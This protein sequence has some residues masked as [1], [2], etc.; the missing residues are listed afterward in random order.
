MAC[1][2]SCRQSCIQSSICPTSEL[3][4]TPMD[5]FS[6]SVTTS[7]SCQSSVI[8]PPSQC[9]FLCQRACLQTPSSIMS[10]LPT[11]YLTAGNLAVAPTFAI[12]HT[13]PNPSSQLQSIVTPC[14]CATDEAFCPCVQSSTPCLQSCLNDCKLTCGSTSQGSYPE[15]RQ[16]C[17][18]FCRK[19]CQRSCNN[20]SFDGN[21]SQ[22][23]GN[24][25]E[26]LD[27]NLANILDTLQKLPNIDNLPHSV[28][29]EMLPGDEVG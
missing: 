1:Q 12:Q 29:Q 9:H 14:E 6:D 17:D 27:N 26:Q 10:P 19:N 13:N 21:R 25:K 18:L 16:Q 8:S 4:E 20:K 23:Y 15:H 5:G 28:Q 11:N 22:D 3:T 24:L 7:N 2:P